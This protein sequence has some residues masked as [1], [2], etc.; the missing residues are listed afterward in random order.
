MKVWLIFLIVMTLSVLIAI[1]FGLLTTKF[2]SLSELRNQVLDQKSLILFV[3]FGDSHWKN[4]LIIVLSTLNLLLIN[5]LLGL[6]NNIINN[7]VLLPVG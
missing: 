3:N 5:G 6:T 1:F 2:N 4:S 7:V